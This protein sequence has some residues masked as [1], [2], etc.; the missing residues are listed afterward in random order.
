MFSISLIK[1]FGGHKLPKY[2]VSAR[3]LAKLVYKTMKDFSR[4][5]YTVSTLISVITNIT[6]ISGVYSSYVL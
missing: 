6:K 5:S 2:T 3:Q 4:L 1:V